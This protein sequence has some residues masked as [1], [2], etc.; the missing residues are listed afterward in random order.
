MKTRKRKYKKRRKTRGGSLREQQE[1]DMLERRRS[2]SKTPVNLQESASLPTL[3]PCTKC[4]SPPKLPQ[5]SSFTS[6]C[7]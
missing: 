7:L 3:T 5:S 2:R 4:D 6:F 1:R